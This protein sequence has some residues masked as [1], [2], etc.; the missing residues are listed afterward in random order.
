VSLLYTAPRLKLTPEEA[1]LIG[2]IAGFIL[3]P[4]RR[5]ALK[6]VKKAKEARGIYSYIFN[7]QK[8]LSFSAG[9]YM[10]WTLPSAKSDSR[11]NRRY[12]TIS[13]SPTEN[14][15]SFTLKVPPKMSS[16]KAT[17]QNYKAGDK[18]FAARL[19]G[20]FT[21]PNDKRTKLVFLAGGVGITP[22][23]SMA[24]L[25]L[26]NQES[27]DIKLFYQATNSDEFA[28]RELFSRAGIQCKLVASDIGQ[29]SQ[30]INGQLIRLLP[31]YQQRIFYVSGPLGFVEAMEKVLFELGLKSNQ[32]KKDYFPGY[33]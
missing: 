14:E 19:A 13:S 4:K 1:L 11:G 6:F 21:L 27:R 22:F 5:Y 16:F 29:P 7:S 2:N 10:E 25:I 26:D 3:E 15:V 18:I 12:L 33:G 20:N 28:F 31:D 17:L 24:K 23:R 32:I 30:T 8:P 9:Q